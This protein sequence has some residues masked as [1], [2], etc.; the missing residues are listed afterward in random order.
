[1]NRQGGLFKSKF[2]SRT[3]ETVVS[4]IAGEKGFAGYRSSS[5]IRMLI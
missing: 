2:K 1:M 5:D 3:A 4:G